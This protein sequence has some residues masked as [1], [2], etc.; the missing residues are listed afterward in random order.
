M[1]N[2]YT[3]VDQRH[4][5][6]NTDYKI[7]GKFLLENHDKWFTA[8][9]IAEQAHIPENATQSNVRFAVAKLRDLGE[10]IVSS[11][12]GFM[13]TFDKELIAKCIQQL[14]KRVLGIQGAIEALE[15]YS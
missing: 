2:V 6:K 13:Y 11:N 10:P 4:F 5:N 12:N 1:S 14:Q 15:R 7:V 9:E 3:T 8:S